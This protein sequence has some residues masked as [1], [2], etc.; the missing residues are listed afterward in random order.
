MVHLRF[1]PE[2]NHRVMT[3]RATGFLLRKVVFLEFEVE[4]IVIEDLCHLPGTLA[5]MIKPTA[6]DQAGDL[7]AQA[8][9]QGDQP[10][11]M[12]TQKFPVDPRPVIKAILISGRDHAAEVAIAGAVFTEQDQ[13]T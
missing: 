6:A 12:F 3:R 9:R 10:F 2:L 5:G 7:T 8:S 4:T 11:V 13:M 1:M